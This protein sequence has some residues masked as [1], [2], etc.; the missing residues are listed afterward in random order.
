M[1]WRTAATGDR[2]SGCPRRNRS[3]RPRRSGGAAGSRVGAGSPEHAPPTLVTHD[4]DDL[5][6]LPGVV[7]VVLVIAVV[8]GLRVR[9]DDRHVP[10]EMLANGGPSNLVFIAQEATGLDPIPLA[11]SRIDPDRVLGHM[12]VCRPLVAEV[13]VTRDA[14]RIVVGRLAGPV[15]STRVHRAERIG[16]FDPDVVIVVRGFLVAVVDEANP[17][18]RCGDDR[19]RGRVLRLDVV[20]VGLRRGMRDVVVDDL[21]DGAVFIRHPILSLGASRQQHDRPHQRGQRRARS[22]G[23]APPLALRSCLFVFRGTLFGGCHPPR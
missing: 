17:T 21:D 5:R 20:H 3:R 23:A 11:E 7:D 19:G 16:M 10:V 13:P 9:W 14:G 4:R 2:G 1:R 8:G 6:L 18:R 22:D 12:C 15:G